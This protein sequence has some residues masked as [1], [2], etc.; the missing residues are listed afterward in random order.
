MTTLS[1]ATFNSGQSTISITPIKV[2]S[3]KPL[4]RRVEL[5]DDLSLTP[6]AGRQS[7]EE[8]AAPDDHVRDV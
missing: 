3:T 6:A 8:S 7:D 2:R 5:A 4:G 1:P